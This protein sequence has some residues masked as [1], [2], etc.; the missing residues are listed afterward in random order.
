LT[1]T[2]WYPAVAHAPTCVDGV[3]LVK[4]CHSLTLIRVRPYAIPTEALGKVRRPIRTLVPPPPPGLGTH[5]PT[6]VPE[7]SAVEV[8]EIGSFTSEVTLRNN[9]A[10]RPTLR[11]AVRFPCTNV[12]G[13]VALTT[14]FPATATFSAPINNRTDKKCQERLRLNLRLPGCPTIS[15]TG[16]TVQMVEDANGSVLRTITPNN[17]TGCLTTLTDLIKVP[18]TPTTVSAGSVTVNGAS[19]G[20]TLTVATTNATKC[21]RAYTIGLSLNVSGGGGGGGAGN[22]SG[23][24]Q[25]AGTNPSQG[26]G[27][28][29]SGTAC[30]NGYGFGRDVPI[31]DL[32]ASLIAVAGDQL[33]TADY[34]IINQS[35]RAVVPGELVTLAKAPTQPPSKILYHIVD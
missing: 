14:G 7:L 16:N 17:V 21:A 1:D 24:F 33:P 23:G 18:C 20:S 13:E 8:G 9:D 19:N 15:S 12:T 11:Q 2:Q 30:C 32:Y 34:Q 26:G 31:L 28:I 22:V 27:A 4:A 29:T 10:C 35:R 3:P 6:I 5:C 25:V